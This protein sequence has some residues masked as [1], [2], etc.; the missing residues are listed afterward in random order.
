MADRVWR[1]VLR[2]IR[3]FRVARVFKMSKN[4]KGMFIL[5]RT[6]RCTRRRRPS[7]WDLACWA[8]PHECG[9]QPQAFNPDPD[10]DPDPNQARTLYKSASALAML[11]FF[12]LITLVVFSTIIYNIEGPVRH[13][14][15]AMPRAARSVRP[16]AACSV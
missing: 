6:A 9:G 11:V 1:Q 10:P 2:I 5:A 14:A 3:I 13:A 4:L 15:C 8:S 12:I 7:R 16:R